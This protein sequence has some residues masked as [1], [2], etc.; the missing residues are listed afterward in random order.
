MPGMRPQAR[1][2]VK[3]D[4]ELIVSALVGIVAGVLLGWGAGLEAALW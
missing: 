3:L 2:G 4:R 1:C